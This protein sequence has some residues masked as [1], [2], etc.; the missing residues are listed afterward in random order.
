VHTDDHHHDDA[1]L[2]RRARLGDRAALA[3]L[4]SRH[5]ASLLQLC[6]RLLADRHEAEDVAQEAGL[7][8]W[9]G[10]AQLR[11]PA[12]FGA[13]LHAIAAN[14]ACGVLRRRRTI[15]LEQLGEPAGMLR[16][17]SAAPPDPAEVAILRELHDQIVTALG[18]LSALS[19][20][21]VI[22][23]YLDG[24]SYAELAVLLGVPVG[25]L[26]GRLVF[27][28]RQLRRELSAVAPPSYHPARQVSLPIT[29]ETRMEPNDCIPLT[30]DSVQLNVHTQQ[31]VVVLRDAAHDRYLPIWIGP[32]EADAIAA[33]LQGQ[34]FPRPMTHDLSLGLLAPFGLGVRQ[35][36]ISRITDQTF[37]A[38]VEVAAADASA[39]W[40]DARPSDALALAV[41]S[42]AAIVAHRDVLDLGAAE[43]VDAPEDPAA[44]AT[45]VGAHPGV[46]ALVNIADAVPEARIAALRAA[47]ADLPLVMLGPAD[48]AIEA[49]AR[50]VGATRY[51]VKP[52]LAG[53]LEAAILDAAVA[54]FQ[55][56]APD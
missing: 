35:V 10:L 23:F 9:V 41:R 55:Q 17:W 27:G 29:L 51:V 49:Q 36:R 22:G 6:R 2:V 11:E 1:E 28:R 52:A 46:I 40:I 37:F 53:T 5:Y 21:A 16:L 4:I 54:A 50:A 45:L 38:E 12:R 34:R 26:K 14:L 32:A 3:P 48:P 42:G 19:R 24:Y 8:A 31:R 25:T 20:E 7:A 47:H 39:H 44:L 43:V 13:W 15:S 30:I 56:R 33:G 18:Q